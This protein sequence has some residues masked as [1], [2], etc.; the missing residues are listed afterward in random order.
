MDRNTATAPQ[1]LSLALAE[2]VTAP[3][4]PDWGRWRLCADT[5]ALYL[6]ADP[7]DPGWGDLWWLPLDGCRTAEDAFRWTAHLSAKTWADNAVIG[8]LVNALRDV[9]GLGDRAAPL[10]HD[11]VRDYAR[12]AAHRWPDLA[13]AVGRAAG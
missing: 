10:S 3:P 8:G 11:Q 7:A 2:Y 1:H 9:L 5:P 4:C 6:P 13:G 12:R